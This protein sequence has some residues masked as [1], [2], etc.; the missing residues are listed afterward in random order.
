[1]FILADFSSKDIKQDLCRLLVKS[2]DEDNERFEMKVGVM[3]MYS[4]ISMFISK[5][6]FFQRKC[7]W[8][9]RVVHYQ[10]RLNFFKYEDT[11]QS[12]VSISFA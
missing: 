5:S 1:L 6:F 8:N 2:K 3:R 10:L 9:M 7:K 11:L 12:I 4:T